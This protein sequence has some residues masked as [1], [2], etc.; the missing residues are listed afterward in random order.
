MEIFDEALLR[1]LAY[2]NS[3]NKKLLD[4]I[5]RSYKDLMNIRLELI[6]RGVG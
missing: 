4:L 3:G 2:L 6:R 5:R 1:E